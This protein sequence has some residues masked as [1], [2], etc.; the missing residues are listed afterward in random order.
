[1]KKLFILALVICPLLAFAQLPKYG[2]VKP[3]DFSLRPLAPE[4]SHSISD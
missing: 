3:E 2:S 4:D 1:M